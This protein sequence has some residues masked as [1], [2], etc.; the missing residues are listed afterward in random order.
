MGNRLNYIPTIWIK[1]CKIQLRPVDKRTV[2]YA[3]LFDSIKANGLW[4]PILV[5][6][7][8]GGTYEVVDG[9]YRFSCCR[10]L[11]IEKIPCLVRALTDFEVIA[12]QIQT[13]AVRLETDPY[14]YAQHLWR[15][16]KE[17]QSMTVAEVS[18]AI[19]KSRAWISQM[20]GLIRLSPEVSIALKRGY[21]SLSVAVELSRLP[22]DAQKELVHFAAVNKE[23]DTIPILRERVRKF[24]EAIK[25]GRMEVYYE[26]LIEP[27][28]HLRPLREITRECKSLGDAYTVLKLVDAKEPIDGWRAA[29]QWVLHLD[30]EAKEAQV[31][32][33]ARRR[34]EEE[35][36]IEAR[37]LDR[38]SLKRIPQDLEK[39][40]G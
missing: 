30:P 26:S 29:L 5:R 32:R 28:A 16:I 24:K 13:N 23:R 9:F 8:S 12:A 3:E 20:L 25:R 36:A 4:Q 7:S 27:V 34:R 33:L 39:Q 15:I 37:K 10:D 14:Y 35:K 18:K 17:D 22:K 1:E 31:K 11:R 38:E 40:H 2:E 19:N 6:P 21:I